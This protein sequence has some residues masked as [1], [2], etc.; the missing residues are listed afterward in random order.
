MDIKEI[1]SKCDHT[2]LKQES[3]W[4]DVKVILDDAKKYH[5]ASVCISPCFIKRAK[6]YAGDEVKL[7]TVIGFPNGTHTTA[8]KVYE[9]KDAIVNGADE[10]DM[11][12]NIGELK[13]GN[14]E[15]VLDEIKQIRAASEGK[16]LKVIIETCLLTDDETVRMCDIVTKSGADYI[17][18]S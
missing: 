1:L 4:E 10:V 14:D 17:K 18:T 11:V 8:S 5:T 13:A 6:D 2:L 7:C 16:I 12:I 3:T 15:Y 9:T